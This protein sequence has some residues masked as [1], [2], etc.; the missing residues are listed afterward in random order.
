MASVISGLIRPAS[1]PHWNKKQGVK[2]GFSW[3]PTVTYPK[4]GEA[5]PPERLTELLRDSKYFR[6]RFFWIIDS[7]G[8]QVAYRQNPSQI[9]YYHKKTSHDLILKARK[10]G[11][12]TE[13]EGDF[14]Y[15]CMTIPN[16]T[17]VTMAHREDDA[18]VHL[19]RLR[20]YIK[21]CGTKDLKIEVP[22]QRDNQTEIYF[23]ETN[24]YYWIGTSGARGWGRGRTIN[25]GH[26]SEIAHYE[27]PAVV[28]GVLEAIP[29]G[30]NSRRVLETTANGIGDVFHSMWVDACDTNS[31]SPY[32]GH[33]FAWWQDPRYTIPEYAMPFNF[34]PT[35][36]ERSWMEAYKLTPNQVMWYRRKKGAMA[37]K[38]LMVQ[39][40]PHNADSAFISSGRHYFDLGQLTVMESKVRKPDWVGFLRDDGKNVKFTA[41]EEG[42]LSIWA[43]PVRG[44]QYLMGCDVGLGVKDGSFSTAPV[45]DRA[46]HELVA[47][48]RGRISPEKFGNAAVD[49]ALFY[50]NAII[51]P[52]SNNAGILMI[53]AIHNRK[54]PHIVNSSQFFQDMQ[55]QY[56]LPTNERTKSQYMG[57]LRSA[58]E[59]LTYVEHSKIALSELRST[60]TNES[61]KIVS[62]HS[63]KGDEKGAHLDCVIARAI[64]LFCLRHLTIDESYRSSEGTGTTRMVTCFAPGKTRWNRRG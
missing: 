38:S 45:F 14:L 46:S 50:N 27:D 55:D 57:A 35:D 7:D 31:N 33:F 1:N 20:F 42:E 30:P 44:R 11:F 43:M 54:Y 34:N 32:T 12:S 17:A 9:D 61:G 13:V 60:V 39:E 15:D 36:E 63:A 6:E 28:T 59:D 21:T 4:P 3:A 8:K 47:E 52:E 24:S 19:E 48:W 58:I 22:V 62:N 56:G 5:I 53:A 26:L 51:A 10:M 2:G 29:D 37:D 23:P 64:A 40:Y 49:L 25:R 41:N 16:I 18:K